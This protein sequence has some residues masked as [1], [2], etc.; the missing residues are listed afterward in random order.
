MA[1]VDIVISPYVSEA[2]YLS[3]CP[4][5][6]LYL[7]PRSLLPPSIL[8][9]ASFGTRAIPGNPPSHIAPVRALYNVDPDIAHTFVHYLYTGTYQT[10]RGPSP[11]AYSFD[12]EE[13][14]REHHRALLAYSA[15]TEYELDGLRDLAKKKA[16]DID[17]PAWCVIRDV[18]RAFRD[19]EGQ[20]EWLDGYLKGALEAF[21]KNGHEQK[22][23][24]NM[25]LESMFACSL[26]DAVA[27]LCERSEAGGA[28]AGWE[29]PLAPAGEE[30]S[31][32]ES[33]V[34][35]PDDS[36]IDLDEYLES[37]SGNTRTLSESD[38]QGGGHAS[39]DGEPASDDEQEESE[40]TTLDDEV[41]PAT[42]EEQPD[43][44]APEQ[45]I[46]GKHAPPYLAFE[47]V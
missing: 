23:D 40:L 3:F 26:V 8:T 13:A 36:V 45:M 43:S 30:V 37:V 27:K 14:E 7:I 6:P 18:E 10:L 5:A 34:T 41:Q 33:E 38:S 25:E 19:L 20:D 21:V 39:S 15:A 42:P 24:L 29:M 31:D 9:T 28:G 4:T 46:D 44:P 22:G 11:F 32:Q 35:G 12:Q 1:N 17:I 47:H 2:I 16:E